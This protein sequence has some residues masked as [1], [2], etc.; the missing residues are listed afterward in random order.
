MSK[1][2]GA[3]VICLTTAATLFSVIKDA[4][5][6]VEETANLWLIALIGP[7]V[8]NFYDRTP[9]NLIRAEYTNLNTNDGFNLRRR[10]IETCGHLLLIRD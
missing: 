9:L 8:R 1:M 7:A 5:T 2:A 10:S 4:H 6:R 3:L